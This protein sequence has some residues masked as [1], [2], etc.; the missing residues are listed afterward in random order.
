[1]CLRNIKW[2]ETCLEDGG[3]HFDAVEFLEKNRL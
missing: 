1:M 2:C 3:G